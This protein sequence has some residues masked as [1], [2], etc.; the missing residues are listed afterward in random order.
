[1]EI[2]EDFKSLIPPLGPDEFLQ[3]ERNCV[4]DGI[5]DPLIIWGD[6]LIDGHNRY[7]IAKKHNLEY[8]TISM[9]FPDDTAAKMWVIQNQLGRRNLPPYDRSVLALKLKSEI[10]ARAK[11]NRVRTA[12]NRV[13]QKSDEQKVSTKDELATIAGVSHDTIHKV[14]KIEAEAPESVK[15]AVRE[16]KMSINQAYNSVHPKAEDPVKRAEREHEQF[17]IAKQDKV[18]N[19]ADIQKDKCNKD[20][21]KTAMYM[22]LLKLFDKVSEF[23]IKYDGELDTLKEIVR[24][25]ER[26][27]IISNCD[28]CERIISEV[29]SKIK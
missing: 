22:D 25:D 27:M 24:D 4:R 16:G 14:E 10:Q 28:N 5:R 3:L 9:D 18:I 21:I 20:I 23:Y 11:A 17:K 26:N 12:E 7:E 29:V 8:K 15:Q 13:S 6:V 19:I 1:M 2:R